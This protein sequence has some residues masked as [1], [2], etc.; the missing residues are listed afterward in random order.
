MVGLCTMAG[1]A[2]QAGSGCHPTSSAVRMRS[3]T[4]LIRGPTRRGGFSF[5]GVSNAASSC[6]PAGG[7]SATAVVVAQSPG[8]AMI[9]RASCRFPALHLSLC[10]HE[11]ESPMEAYAPTMSVTQVEFPQNRCRLHKLSF[12]DRRT[13]RDT[14]TD[15]PMSVTQVEFPGRRNING[16][17]ELLVHDT[18]SP[19][20]GKACPKSQALRKN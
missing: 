1:R 14:R 5:S 11:I 4:G 3:P 9:V 8:S 10:P 6:D 18:W 7:L 20:F 16:G 15:R 12:R 13:D 19:H 17:E 2:S